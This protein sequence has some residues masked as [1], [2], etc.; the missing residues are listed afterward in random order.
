MTRRNKLAGLAAGLALGLIGL[1]SSVLAQGPAPA[2]ETPPVLSPLAAPHQ[3][4]VQTP[5]AT[6]KPPVLPP[7]PSA[8]EDSS[9]RQVS[10]VS[11]TGSRVSKLIE[12]METPKAFRVVPAA[13]VPAKDINVSDKLNS[14]ESEARAELTEGIRLADKRAFKAALYH[15]DAAISFDPSYAVAY[16]WRAHALGETQSYEKA[17]SDVNKAIELCP[18]ELDFR[19]NR[20]GIYLR[21][22]DYDSAL[23]DVNLVISRN[24]TKRPY[25]LRAQIFQAMG[26]SCAAR[27][28][29]EALLL[30]PDDLTALI[31]LA[32]LY[33]ANS[34]D[35]V[36]NGRRAIELA[37]R[38]CEITG[39]KSSHALAVLAAAHAELGDFDAAIRWHDKVAFEGLRGT[40]NGFLV[41]SLYVL[42]CP[43]RYRTTAAKVEEGGERFQ[44]GVGWSFDDGICFV[45]RF[46]AGIGVYIDRLPFGLIWIF[47]TQP[48]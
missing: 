39:W 41:R 21:K 18:T 30:S 42:R 44:A 38:A 9:V 10:G 33:A 22:R 25:I 4:L 28:L 13:P 34:D 17:L 27:D 37:T 47:P 31:G 20:A 1:N 19:C 24:P 32:W 45:L 3:V 5:G 16:V 14:L 40:L 15:L 46:T 12:E 6:E 8:S 43:D 23:A 29:E 2:K 35:S 36:R 26:D 48:L 7:K 11:A